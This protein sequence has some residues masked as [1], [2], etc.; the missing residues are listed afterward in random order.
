MVDNNIWMVC[1]IH[2]NTY[3]KLPANYNR[4]KIIIFIRN[5][6]TR[7]ISGFKNKYCS[8]RYVVDKLDMNGIK[9]INSHHF[10]PQL[11]EAWNKKIN[12]NKYMTEL[13]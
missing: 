1:K 9:N 13:T 4:Y 8:G 6:Y 7:I 3:N 12:V 2:L 11:S 5:P 10:T